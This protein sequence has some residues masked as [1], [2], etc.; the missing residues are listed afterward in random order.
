MHMLTCVNFCETLNLREALGTSNTHRKDE[1]ILYA[2]C[3]LKDDIALFVHETQKQNLVDQWFL[4]NSNFCQRGH[5]AIVYG[6]IF[7][8]HNWER[9][10]HSVGRERPGMLLNILQ[11]VGHPLLQRICGPKCP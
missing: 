6:E 9:G 4:T 8:L 11:C 7:S 1:Y 5:L 2:C 10:S 3:D